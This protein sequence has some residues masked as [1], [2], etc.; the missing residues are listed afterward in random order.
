MSHSHDTGYLIGDLIFTAYKE[1]YLV[2]IFVISLSLAAVEVL[3]YGKPTSASSLTRLIVISAVQLSLLCRS[4]K[5]PPW[6]LAG[7]ES[8]GKYF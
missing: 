2:S 8:S 4:F 5:V 3:S 6:L 1:N 7:L